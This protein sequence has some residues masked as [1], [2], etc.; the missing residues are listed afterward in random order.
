V[1]CIAQFQTHLI[2]QWLLVVSDWDMW[3]VNEDILVDETGE[4]TTD[5]RS[6]P[7]YPMVSPVSRDQSGTKRPGGVHG[8][9]RK[10][11]S[12]KDVGSNDKSCEKWAE[13]I[14][15]SFLRIHN[16]GVDSEEK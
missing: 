4:S 7:I 11:T 15:G 3:T 10:G 12:C 1:T 6:N 2:Q 13:P 16:S 14:K 8:G 9:A 5:Q